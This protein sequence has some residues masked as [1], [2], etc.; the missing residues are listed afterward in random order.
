MQ[1][2]PLGTRVLGILF[3]AV[4][5]VLGLGLGSTAQAATSISVGGI[6]KVSANWTVNVSVNFQNT[7]GNPSR[8]YVNYIA[9]SSP[10]R[11]D[12]TDDDG[13]RAS[14]I[15]LIDPTGNFVVSHSWHFVDYYGGLYHYRADPDLYNIS[16]VKVNPR[17]NASSTW[18][19]D[20]A[21]AVV[22]HPWN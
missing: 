13:T 18:C 21:I 15:Y 20:Y 10:G 2:P 1:L 22:L 17:T 8:G 11:L 3:T 4:V 7:S 5:L 12:A 16:T 9:M 6:C 19:T 14:E